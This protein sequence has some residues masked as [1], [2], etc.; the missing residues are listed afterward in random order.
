MKCGH[1]FED[2]WSKDNDHEVACP[3]CKSNS[4]RRLIPKKKPA[5]KK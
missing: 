1:E 5:A 3:Q 2:S 4:C